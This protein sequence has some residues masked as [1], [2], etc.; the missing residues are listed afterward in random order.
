[1]STAPEPSEFKPAGSQLTLAPDLNWTF[2]TPSTTTEAG[3]RWTEDEKLGWKTIETAKE[4][5]RNIYPMCISGLA[6]RPIAFVSSISANGEE[7][8]A[9]FSWFNQVCTNPPVISV[10]IAVSSNKHKDTAQNIKDTKQFVVNIISEPF[11]AQANSTSIDAP[12]DINEWVLSGLTKEPSTSVAPAR[13]KESAFS[14]ECELLQCIE[15]P[16]GSGGVAADLILGSVKYIHVRKA[17]LNERGL[18][19]PARMLAVS[20]MGDNSYARV[21]DTFRIPR[22]V[23]ADVKGELEEKFGEE[24]SASKE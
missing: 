17:V 12:P 2:G 23:W 10:S 16:N 6:P 13:V 20:R 3:R 9:P 8:L 4:D 7:N 19:D 24:M 11:V 18:V 1:M 14:M 21:G 5:P 15:V 22:P